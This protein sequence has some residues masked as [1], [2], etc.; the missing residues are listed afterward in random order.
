[1]KDLRITLIQTKLHWQD[2]VKN[3]SMFDALV[4]KIK[5]GSTD[6]ILLPEMFSTGFTMQAASNAEEMNGPSMQFMIIT[7]AEKNA[8][9]C[10]SLIIREKKKYFNRLIWMQP[11]GSYSHYD[12]RHLFS[13]AKE[14]LTYT[15]GTKKLIVS[16]RGWKIC[17]LV[18]YDLRFPV[19]SRRTRKNDYDLLIYVA[20]WPERRRL[21]W[22]QLLPARAIENQCFVAGLNRIGAD[23]N[24]ISHTGDS[25]VIDPMGNKISRTKGSQS[26]IETV[27]LQAKVLTDWRD[28]L[29]TWMD[30]DD[31]VI[32]KQNG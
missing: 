24:N 18:C 25:A 21:A 22:S 5:K 4:K 20:N 9:V 14:Q 11:D 13:M 6:V 31:F 15:Q 32:K 12:K 3:I 16:W 26:S 8:A 10:G 1:M 29:K 30:A 19:W 2:A 28:H 7:A 27:S 23:G 17:P